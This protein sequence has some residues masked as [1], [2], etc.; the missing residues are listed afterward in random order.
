MTHVTRCLFTALSIAVAITFSSHSTFG[1]APGAAKKMELDSPLLKPWTGPHGGVPPW[2]LVRSE[3]FVTAFDAAID[4]A[5]ADIKVITD[6]SEKP[7]F[8]NTIVAMERAGRTLS[9]LSA[10]FF[11]YASNLNVGPIQDIEK[12]IVPKLSEH[13]DSI[14]QNKELFAR[15]SAVYESPAMKDGSFDLAQRRLVDDTYKTF[16]RKGAKLNRSDK[17][18][19]SQMNTRLARLFTDFSQNVLADEKGYVTWIKD[20]SELGGLPDSVIAAMGNAAKDRDNKGGDWAITNT[21][22]S[23]D[24]FLTYSSNRPLRERVWQNYYSRG[25]NGDK[26]D[27]NKIIAEILKIRAARAKLLGYETHAHWRMEPTM[28]KKPE[29]AMDL[30]MK[31]WPKALARVREEVADMQAIADEEGAKIKIEPWDYRYYAEK[32]RKAKYDLDFNEVKPYLQLDKLREAMMWAATQLYGLHFKQLSGI[33]VFHPDVTVWEVTDADGKHVG[34]W[35]L[36]PYAREG[37]RSGAW[38]TDYRAQEN[39]GKPITTIVSNNSNFIKGADG[40]AVLISWDDAVTLFHEFGHALHGLLS[41]VNYRSQSGTSVARDY[42]E[43]P[44]QIN[45]HWLETPEILNQF[46]IHHKTGEAIPQQL[47]DKIKKAS[48]FNQGFDTVEY[49]A[50]ALMDMKLH[51]AGSDDIDPDAFERETLAEMGMPS[52]LPMRHR[53]PHFMHI[54]SSDSYSAGYYS[55]LWADALT[56]DAAERFVEA[57]SFYDKDVAKSLHDN[58]MSIGDTIDPAEGFRRFRGR[59]VDTSALLRKRGFPVD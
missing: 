53:T 23:M 26:Y 49:L 5:N 47:L 6:N 7:S 22:S 58:V 50:S 46:A 8:E 43:F 19:L 15:I 41:K 32:V 39:M 20:K 28:A 48:T 29:A 42:V 4:Q 1:Q 10:I 33:P 59:D 11:V 35:Y 51:L 56:A 34:L 12:V 36:D 13:E 45:E 2:N 37:K 17:A 54:F 18:K 16:L 3:E 25:D 27:N 38:M 21:R 24:P 30:M 31:V 44:S 55:Y 52:E 57:G 14:Y 40:E 9:R